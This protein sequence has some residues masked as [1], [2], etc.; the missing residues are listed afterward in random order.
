MKTKEHRIVEQADGTATI[1]LGTLVQGLIAL[2][3]GAGAS[4]VLGVAVLQ[5]RAVYASDHRDELEIQVEANQT[6]IR[7]SQEAAR[8]MQRNVNWQ[9]TTLEKIAGK[10]N[11]DAT[12]PPPVSL[13][14]IQGPEPVE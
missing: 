6:A 2:A 14:P 9:S 13:A 7:D 8:A 12:A 5:V 11:V 4:A 3:I 10:L 1:V